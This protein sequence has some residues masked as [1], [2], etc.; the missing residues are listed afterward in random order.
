[1]KRTL[2]FLATLL[3][4]VGCGVFSKKGYA[5]GKTFSDRNSLEEYL[6]GQDWKFE[7]LN[8]S[9]RYVPHNFNTFGFGFDVKGDSINCYLP[10]FG[11][12]YKSPMGRT[13]GPM[14]FQGKV[15]EYTIGDGRDDAVYVEIVAMPK[16]QHTRITL[17]VST[18]T[19][20]SAF[21]TMTSTDTQSLHYIGAI[22]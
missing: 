3:L 6:D 18:F 2:L 10:F 20:G 7:L 11:V 19:N 13:D 16:G 9:G 8:V 22:H 4:V 15:T 12:S 14:T 17:Q 1:M 21:V 5:P